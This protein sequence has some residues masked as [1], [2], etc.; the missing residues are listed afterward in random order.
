MPK[1]LT[2][3]DIVFYL[4]QNPLKVARMYLRR[5]DYKTSGFWASRAFEI[6]LKKE[7]ESKVKMPK[8]N[9]EKGEL[10]DM[11]GQLCETPEYCGW[12]N[13]LHKSRKLRN[14]AIHPDKPF[15]EDDAKEFFKG[16]EN[17]QNKINKV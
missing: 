7:F 8:R 9:R 13:E 14:K 17:F 11:I 3:E 1:N 4:S 2:I 5:E 15:K 10:E 6:F 16:V 12:K